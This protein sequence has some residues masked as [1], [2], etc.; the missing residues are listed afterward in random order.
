MQHRGVEDIF[1]A[2]IDGLVGFK[3]AIEATFPHTEV[4]RCI[5]H[6][7]RNS[8]RYLSFKDRKAFVKDLNPVYTAI[9]EVAAL[10]AL[11]K[12]DQKW[13]EKYYIAIKPWRDHWNEVAT[14]FK[15]PKEIRR[16][17]YTTNAI[18]S[19]NCQLRKVTKSKNIFP[20]DDSLLKMLYLSMIDITKKWTIRTMR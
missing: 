1:I 11:D 19:F 15:Y 5:V 9:D 10:D 7:I 3:E 16:L 8:T 6:M 17:I 14:M 13:G 12:L 2:S 4:Q 18:E 20:T